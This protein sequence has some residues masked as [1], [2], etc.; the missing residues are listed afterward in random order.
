MFLESQKIKITS[1][2]LCNINLVHQHSG[3]LLFMNSNHR[4]LCRLTSVRKWS[5]ATTTLATITEHSVI[6]RAGERERWF[7]KRRQ[8]AKT[9]Q[10]SSRASARSPIVRAAPFCKN[11]TAPIKKKRFLA[12]SNNFFLNCWCSAR[13]QNLTAGS[14]VACAFYR[15]VKSAPAYTLC[16]RSGS[17]LSSFSLGPQH[18]IEPA[19]KSCAALM[20]VNSHQM[21][22]FL[23][24]SFGALFF[25]PSRRAAWKREAPSS[26]YA[27]IA[28]LARTRSKIIV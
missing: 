8:F 27:Y 15:S 14:R 7:V 18:Q 20:G 13:H 28:P 11:K 4:H 1:D 9:Q 25:V 5:T 2:V 21:H 22:V 6:P 10:H 23:S 12:I 26:C 17:R 24:F 3:A 19:D 16:A